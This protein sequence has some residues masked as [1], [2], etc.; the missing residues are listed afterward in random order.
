MEKFK[1][2]IY[3][4][5]NAIIVKVILWWCIILSCTDIMRSSKNK[6]KYF[7]SSSVRFTMFNPLLIWLGTLLLSCN[8]WKYWLSMQGTHKCGKMNLFFIFNCKEK[9]YIK[10]L[11]YFIRKWFTL[12][13]FQVSITLKYYVNT[14]EYT[15]TIGN[16]LHCRCKGATNGAKLICFLFL[17][18]MKNTI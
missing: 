14:L 15:V 1:N 8:H 16:G 11:L 17:I 10:L 5:F 12:Q 7:F 18:E 2:P 13:L 4:K 9:Y 3:V 6:M